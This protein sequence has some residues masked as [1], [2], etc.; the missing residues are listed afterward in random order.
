MNVSQFECWQTTACKTECTISELEYLGHRDLYSTL[1]PDR[2]FVGVGQGVIHRRKKMSIDKVQTKARVARR[3]HDFDVRVF[4]KRSL[5][6][7]VG[8]NNLNLVADYS[9]MLGLLIFFFR[10]V[11]LF[12]TTRRKGSKMQERQHRPH[13]MMVKSI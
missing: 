13:L 7:F 5:T 8:I 3:T 12:L 4:V 1:P 6:H 10:C 11:R 9:C 2:D